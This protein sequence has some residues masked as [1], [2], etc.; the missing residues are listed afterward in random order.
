LADPAT[1]L[2]IGKAIRQRFSAAYLAD[3]ATALHVGQ[4]ITMSVWQTLSKGSVGMSVLIA[5]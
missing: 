5:K 4:A 2:H 1:A 3:P